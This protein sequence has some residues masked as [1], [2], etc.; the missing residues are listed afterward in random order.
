MGQ[1]TVFAI[2]LALVASIL[3]LPSMLVLWERWHR[4][5]ATART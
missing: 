5:R 2:G 1:V 3:V 4:R